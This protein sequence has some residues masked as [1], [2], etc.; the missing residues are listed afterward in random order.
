MSVK[1]DEKDLAILTLIQE[2]SK[3][4]ANQ[5]AKKINTP[6]TTIFAKIKRMEELGIIKQYRAILSPE[7]LHLSTVAFILASVSYR[8]KDNTPITQRD[9][10]EEIARF[11][12]VQE[13]HIITGDWDLLVKLRAE[14]VET[15]GKFVVDKLRNIKGLEKTLTCMVFETVK[16]STSLPQA[17]RKSA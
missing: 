11:P 5:I 6:I 1:L 12:E 10:A 14:N 17:M 8:A 13:V 16:E 4:T 15:V 7:K 2:N 9:V 3:L